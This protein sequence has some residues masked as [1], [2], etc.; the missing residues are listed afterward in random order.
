MVVFKS[1]TPKAESPKTETPKLESP[2][3]APVSASALKP[4]RVCLEFQQPGAKTVCVA[5]TFN[6]WKPEKAP[7]VQRANGL[8]VGDLAVPPGRHEYLFVVDG[9]WIPDPKARETVQNPF[10]GKN[11]VLT[12]SV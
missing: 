1:E 7:L 2:K 3:P 5:G 8:W 9:R 6:E 11:S 10:G 12:V 4:A